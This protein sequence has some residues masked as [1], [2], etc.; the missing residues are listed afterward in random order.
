MGSVW[1]VSQ[2]SAVTTNTTITAISETLRHA[3]NTQQ[4]HSVAS[5]STS[6]TPLFTEM[7]DVSSHWSDGF[8]KEWLEWTEKTH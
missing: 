8:Q 7:Q 6:D 4:P 3:R 2:P 1:E 5:H